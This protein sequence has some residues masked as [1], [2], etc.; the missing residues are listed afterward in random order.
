MRE[1]PGFGN[2]GLPARASIYA[3]LKRTLPESQLESSGNL[4]TVPEVVPRTALKHKLTYIA[5]A[6]TNADGSVDTRIKRNVPGLLLE[7]SRD[8]MRAAEVMP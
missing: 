7:C 2:A 8:K 1:E 6:A 5:S 4:K 3:F